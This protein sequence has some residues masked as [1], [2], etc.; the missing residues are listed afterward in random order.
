M[1]SATKGRVA[2][3]IL[4][5]QLNQKVAN[6]VLVNARNMWSTAAGLTTME[7]KVGSCADPLLTRRIYLNMK[8]NNF[9]LQSPFSTF[10]GDLE[11]EFIT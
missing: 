6:L 11:R 8:N 3:Q 2:R 4:M 10:N 7:K 5:T 1:P 9:S